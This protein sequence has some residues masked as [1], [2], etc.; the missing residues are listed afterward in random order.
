MSS[1]FPTTRWS[2]IARASRE[3]AAGSRNQMGELLAHYWRPML[4]HLRYKGLSYESAED[5]LQDFMI[6]LL[7]QDLLSVADPQKGRFRSLL[8]TALDRFLISRVRYQKAA[9]RAPASLTSLDASVPDL[10]PAAEADASLAF[11][12]AWALDVLAEALARMERECSDAGETARW[13]VFHERMVVPLISAAPEADFSVL[14]GRCGLDSGKAAMNLLV[15]AKRQFSRLLRDVIREYVTRCPTAGGPPRARSNHQPST[16]SSGIDGIDLEEHLVRQTIER[17]LADL[18][19]VLA[20]TRG[21]A[22]TVGTLQYEDEVA[23][24]VKARYWRLLTERANESDW[25]SALFGAGSEVTD[26]ALSAGCLE[27]LQQPLASVPD[28]D[29]ESGG[30]IGDALRNEHP[31][32]DT[33]KALKQWFNLQRFSPTRD[34]PAPLAN[35]LYLLVLAAALTKCG[36]RITGLADAQFRAGLDWLAGQS[37]LAEDLQQIVLNAQSCLPQSSG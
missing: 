27:I 21:V 19:Q 2:L 34:V 12:R 35:G 16:N 23:R 20:R 33:L 6:E 8:L 32:L 17:E 1:Q 36:Q 37:W 9:K 3:S 29:H 31:S 22:E 15:T 7:D 24:P 4:I 26:D 13:E 28:C 10:V 30:T 11:E 14:A 18:Q 25:W 5:V